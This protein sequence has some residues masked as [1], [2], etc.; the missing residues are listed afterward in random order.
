M[1]WSRCTAPPRRTAGAWSASEVEKVAE[2][3]EDYY[4]GEGEAPGQ[5]LGDGAEDLQLVRTGRTGTDRIFGRSPDQ[6]LYPSTID[7]R[8]RRAW[9]AHNLAER[10]AAE[11]QSAR[12][13]C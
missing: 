12:R 13:Y 3:A 11:G 8:A 7:G 4:S 10:E 9:K 6:V 1:T 2:G 5:W